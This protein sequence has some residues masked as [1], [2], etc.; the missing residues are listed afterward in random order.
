[1]KNL[2]LGILCAMIALAAG[3]AS[4]NI[5]LERG[6]GTL[7]K[8]SG[9]WVGW[10]RAT[11]PTADPYTRAF[12]GRNAVLPPPPSDSLLFTARTDS[13]GRALNGK[14]NYVVVGRFPPAR[15]WTV[16]VYDFNGSVVAN[17][18]NRYSHS[19]ASIVFQADGQV[20]IVVSAV[21]QPGN[22]LPMGSHGGHSLTLAFYDTPLATEALLLDPTLPAIQRTGCRV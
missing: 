9:P 7:K 11:A 21:P 2:V 20:R 10:L 17:P 18:S 5:A 12:F 4:A 15:Q 19:N 22:W 1:M 6:I 3:L 16:T 13:E 8:R 14:C